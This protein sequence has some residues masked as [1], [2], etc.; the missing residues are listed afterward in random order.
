M[1]RS[2][3]SL[4]MAVCTLVPAPAAAAVVHAEPLAAVGDALTGD[5]SIGSELE[6]KFIPGGGIAVHARVMPGGESVV[7]LN[8]EIVWSSQDWPDVPWHSADGSD[9]WSVGPGGDFLV[10]PLLEPSTDRAVFGPS[11]RLLAT[12]DAAPVFAGMTVRRVW[13]VNVRP[14]GSVSLLGSLDAD[15]DGDADRSVMWFADDVA[16][17]NPTTRIEDGQVFDGEELSNINTHTVSDNGEHVIFSGGRGALYIVI[18]D[19]AVMAKE[20]EPSFGPQGANWGQMASSMA[21]NNDGHHTFSG[22]F[23]NA[24]DPFLAYDGEVVVAYNDTLEGVALGESPAPEA[25]LSNGGIVAHRWGNALF[26]TCDGSAMQET[27]TLLANVGDGIDLDGDGIPEGELV[28]LGS[29][30]IRDDGQVLVAARIAVD[31]FDWPN[32][33]LGLQVSCCGNGWVEADE[34]CDGSADCTAQCEFADDSTDDG[35]DSD[36]ATDSS[37]SGVDDDADSGSD[38]AAPDGTG[39]SG[40]T[41]SD[42]AAAQ[43]DDSTGDSNAVGQDDTASDGCGCT[44][45]PNTPAPWALVVP[46]GLLLTR[47]RRQG[48]A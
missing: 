2:M 1:T 48:A 43:P 15:G 32:L 23:W 42:G 29:I 47:R 24:P 9:D 10:R 8:S 36:G 35:G 21:I 12:G 44:S 11:G 46:P 22:Y 40:A 3:S 41:G 25:V 7:A 16:L 14:D 17:T 27:T 19:D 34:A 18:A 26:A 6:A 33:I 45:E 31:D 20:G 13:D 28:D 5:F 4:I 37:A 38:D 39:P 30:D